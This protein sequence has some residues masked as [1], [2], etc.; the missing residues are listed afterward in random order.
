MKNDESKNSRV[1]FFGYGS[2][3]KVTDDNKGNLSHTY[4]TSNTLLNTILRKRDM[5]VCDDF[6]Q[7]M[8]ISRSE[9]SCNDM[10]GSPSTLTPTQMK[11]ITALAM[12]ADKKVKDEATQ[13]HIKNLTPS[14]LQQR[15]LMPQAPLFS[16]AVRCN[17]NIRELAK[18]IY[19]KQRIG[20]KQVDKVRSDLIQLTQLK[21]VCEYRTESGKITIK[22][23]LIHLGR[24]IEVESFRNGEKLNAVEIIFDDAFFYEV[25]SKYTL[26]PLTLLKLWNDTG[27]NS[28]LFVTILFTL[29]QARGNCIAKATREAAR[30]RQELIKTK[31][32]EAAI[33]KEI[34]KE[35]AKHLTYKES[36]ESF[37]NKSTSGKYAVDNNTKK[38]YTRKGRIAEDLKK[39]TDALLQIG[40]ITRYYESRTPEGEILCNFVLNE[41][42]LDDERLRLMQIDSE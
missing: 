35:R 3:K 7:G 14:N 5:I 42:W 16:T 25:N 19:S 15:S 10:Q 32:D 40:I 8:D 21:Q 27:V 17:I 30:I 13:K 29:L 41:S 18:I 23:P 39:A 22:T 31:K 2:V 1:W 24:E 9:V 26:A 34:N 33:E 37:L 38:S 36:L 20:G 11:L 6:L 28:G 12:V 4:L